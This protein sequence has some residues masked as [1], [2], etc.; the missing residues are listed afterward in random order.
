M[1]IVH[2]S[3]VA[4]AVDEVFT[5]HSRPGAI[6]RLLPPWQP[7]RVV[8]EAG[9]LR[10]GR[11]VLALPA[12]LRWVA[13]HDPAAY[14]PPHRFADRL[15]SLPLRAALP[16]RHTHLFAAADDDHTRVTDRVDTRAPAALLRSTF[17]YRHRQLADDLAAQRRAAA[18]GVL[19]STVA[20]TGSSG[21]IGTALV[22]LLSTGGCR[23]IHLV[24]RA[25]RTGDER[26]W[27]PDDPARDLLAG[28][29][30][31]VHLAGACIA[32]RFT[33]ARMQAIHDSRVGATRRL[34]ELAA[35]GGPRTL[36]TAS[37][38]AYYGRDRGEEVLTEASARGDTSLADVVAAGEAATTAAVEEGVRVV[39]VRTGIVQTPRGGTLRLLRR[40]FA[41]G[42]GGR[43]APGRQWLSWIGIDD[44]T[45]IFH[46][47]LVD[48]E[49]S[50]AVNAVAPHPVRTIEYTRLLG[51]VLRRPTLLPI[52]ALGRRLLLGGPAA[53]ELATANLHVRPQRL[54]DAG[55]YFR[56]ARL[57]PALRHLLGR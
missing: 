57:E 46:R 11:A 49:L 43:L 17:A 29:D 1:G 25:P 33:E 55:H 32:G 45:D 52:P 28:V 37:A 30:A 34:A 7:V 16:W 20:V 40:L 3:T 26:R 41:V 27:D 23:V 5:W 24:R 54:Q 42:L 14:D 19:P 38:I 35:H 44:L 13:E 31:V 4:A 8:E 39:Q 22:A 47:A 50:G 9:S 56:R 6:T 48:P 51:T 10:D 15:A 18:Y 2:S 36:V 21:L 12:G 53:R